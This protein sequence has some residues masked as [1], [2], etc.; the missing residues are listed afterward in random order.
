MVSVDSLVQVGPV[1]SLCWGLAE[2]GVSGLG[3][4]GDE[5]PAQHQGW[6]RGCWTR[7]QEA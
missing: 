5:I 1:P 2:K 3:K 7:S 4:P 6:G